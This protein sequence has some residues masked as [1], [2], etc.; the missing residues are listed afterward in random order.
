MTKKGCTILSILERTYKGFES[1]LTI[2]KLL[3]NK[4]LVLLGVRTGTG[5]IIEDWNALI[6]RYWQQ[7]VFDSNPKLFDPPGL[8]HVGHDRDRPG[9]NC[10]EH[11]I[12]MNEVPCTSWNQCSRN[13]NTR[14]QETKLSNKNLHRNV[15]RRKGYQPKQEQEQEQPANSNNGKKESPYDSYESFA[16]EF[17]R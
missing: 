3:T 14:A 11:H 5:I 7:D 4:R 8:I 9:G 16:E 6:Q 1:K 15:R 2:K 13:N 17:F 10:Y 12:Q